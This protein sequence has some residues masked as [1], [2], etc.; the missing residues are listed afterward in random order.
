MTK[1]TRSPKRETAISLK[2]AYS[3][4]GKIIQM[5]E[6]DKYCV[7]IM[8]QNLAVIGL[9]KAANNKLMAGHLDT[10]VAKALSSKNNKKQKQ[11][12]EEI[13]FISKLSNK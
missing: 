7:D 8:Q 3:L 12:I 6:D 10:C 13:L 1:E 11:V 2:K 5:V 9:L 4:L